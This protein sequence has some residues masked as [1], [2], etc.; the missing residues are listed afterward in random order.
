[1]SFRQ[2]KLK[3]IIGWKAALITATFAGLLVGCA[4]ENEE[5]LFPPP[6]D[7]ADRCGADTST[8]SNT[9]APLLQGRCV[10]C[11]GEEFPSGDIQLLTY[12]QVKAQVDR[13]S[14]WGA[15]NEMEGYDVMPPTGKLEA[16]EL[17]R[18]KGWIDRGAKND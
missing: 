16:C 5:E 11:H 2:R 7:L 6:A 17:A 4:Y 13:G 18:V 12:E 15:L 10:S 8:Y 14:F 3:P 1:M 9:I